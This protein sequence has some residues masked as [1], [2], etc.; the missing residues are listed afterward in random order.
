M[1]LD[2]GI[3]LKIIDR[4]VFGPIPEWFRHKDWEPAD[5]YEINY[6]RK[7]W[8]VRAEI[9]TYLGA[10]DDSY[11][12]YMTVEDLR[13]VNKIV[14]SIYNPIDWGNSI[15][16]WDEIKDCYLRNLAYA[17]RMA[18]FLKKRPASSY[19]IFFY[20]SYQDMEVG[21]MADEQ[22]KEL[23]PDTENEPKTEVDP[24]DEKIDNFLEEV[25]NKPDIKQAGGLIGIMIA[26]A[27]AVL[28]VIEA[29]N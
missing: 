19:E 3:V 13:T 27:A 11:E 24:I 4:E 2:N 23:R 25:V 8:N 10:D 16:D 29:C 9:L 15:W 18:Q 12:F 7:C 20:D 17:K 5:E 6:W 28:L 22:N 21:S 1:G 14:K 26:I